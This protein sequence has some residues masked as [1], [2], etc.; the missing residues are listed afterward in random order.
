[1]DADLRL[2]LVVEDLGPAVLE[3]RRVV[4]RHASERLPGR[5]MAY[6]VF[7]PGIVGGVH[8]EDRQGGRKQKTLGD[9]SHALPPS[10]SIVTLGGSVR[11]ARVQSGEPERIVD[12]CIVA[13][14]LERRK[15]DGMIQ[16]A[17]AAVTAPAVCPTG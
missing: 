3:R 14:D 7:E 17:G 8:A 1:L 6:S 9:E 4:K 11:S 13:E 16:A 12:P 5:V 2:R 15:A 10:I